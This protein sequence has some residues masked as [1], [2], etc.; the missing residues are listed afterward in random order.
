MFLEMDV[1]VQV[2]FNKENYKA[3]VGKPKKDKTIS[4]K[5][6]QLTVFNFDTI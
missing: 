2:M 1:I 5:N 6:L 3:T 4:S